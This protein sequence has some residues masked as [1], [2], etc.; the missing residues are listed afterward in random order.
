MPADSRPADPTEPT[1]ADRV[2]ELRERQERARRMGGQEGLRKHRE[3]GRLP[4]RERIDLLL[5]PGSWFEIGALAL[6]ERRTDKY[7]PCDAVVTGFGLLDGRRVGV[8]GIDA[9]VLAGTTAPISM[10]KQG[11]L[12]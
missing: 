9:S 3:S 10:R 8:I 1:M 5:D 11:R 2:S 12:I 7:V 6:P 4:V